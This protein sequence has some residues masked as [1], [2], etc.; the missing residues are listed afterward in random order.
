MAKAT[1]PFHARNP[2]NGQHEFYDVGDKVPDVVAATVSAEVVDRKPKVE[3][4]PDPVVSLT[5]SELDA[6]VA[7]RV[8]REVGDKKYT[9]DELDQATAAAADEARTTLI[10]ELEQLGGD[11][12]VPDPA[13]SKAPGAPAA[14]P[15][16]RGAGQ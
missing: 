8:A 3:D 2:E 13:A 5:Q 9:Q 14:P 10:A 12:P 16:G 6:Q 4:D 7:E 11:A 1:K 15:K